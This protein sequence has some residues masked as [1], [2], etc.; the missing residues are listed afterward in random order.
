MTTHV[1]NDAVSE[2]CFLL[3]AS[4]QVRP[5]CYDVLFFEFLLSYFVKVF[6]DQWVNHL[7][8]GFGVRLC[9]CRGRRWRRIFFGLLGFFWTE[10]FLRGNGRGGVD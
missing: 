10:F 4:A 8:S 7:F 1:I 6:T 5:D 2:F 9:T 3:E